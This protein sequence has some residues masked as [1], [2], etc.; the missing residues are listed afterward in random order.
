MPVLCTSQSGC[1]FYRCFTKH[2]RPLAAYWR[3]LSRSYSC[4]LSTCSFLWRICRK[5]K[6]G[7]RPLPQ[8]LRRCNVTNQMRWLCS[9]YETA[10][11]MNTMGH[12]CDP[13]GAIDSN[14]YLHL[15]CWR[16]L[17]CKGLWAHSRL[18][19]VSP[20]CSVNTTTHSSFREYF[21][22]NSFPC[23]AAKLKILMGLRGKHSIY[24]HLI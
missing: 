8:S 15:L 3:Y 9:S 21:L 18:W 10:A 7:R 19:H 6:G 17:Q 16:S 22:Q 5:H 14:E 24:D 1:L 23:C 2:P 11:S 20:Y 13:Y 4:C 12:L